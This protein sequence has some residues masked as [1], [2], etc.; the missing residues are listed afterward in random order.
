MQ[1]KRLRYFFKNLFG[2]LTGIELEK[3]GNRAWV[4]FRRKCRSDAWFSYKAQI[5]SLIEN[6]A[7]DL[8][9]DVGANRGQFAQQLRHFYAGDIL[10]FEPVS[11]TFNELSKVAST[12]PNWQV[13]QLALGSQNSSQTIHISNDSVFS[14][15]LNTNE[16]CTERF[17]T[18]SEGEKTE[19]ITVRRLDELINTLV[20]DY[21]NRRIFIKMDTQGYDLEV[22]QGL[23]EILDRVQVLQSEISLIPIYQDMPHWTESVRC[24]ENAGFGVIGVFPVSRDASGRV[25][26]YDCLMTKAA[27]PDVD[28]P[29]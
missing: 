16:Y 2:K 11:S 25:I 29:H 18:K 14:S 27:T 10:S 24:Y 3:I 26:E 19:T 28:A 17:G 7:I 9:I 1:T 12:D 4:L 13:Q 15:L 23:G 22:F 5:R 6:L 8:V 20:P 21:K